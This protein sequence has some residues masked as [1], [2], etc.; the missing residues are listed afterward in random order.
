MQKP[1]ILILKS[2]ILHKKS[3]FE[4]V[5]Q[6]EKEIRRLSIGGSLKIEITLV[7][8]LSRYQIGT[9]EI[10]ERITGNNE[11]ILKELEKNSPLRALILLNQ[12][13]VLIKL[14]K[15]SEAAQ[16]FQEASQSSL[17]GHFRKDFLRWML[18]PSEIDPDLSGVEILKHA[19]NQKQKE[20]N[21]LKSAQPLLGQEA[22]N[23]GNYP[24][25]AQHFENSLAVSPSYEVYFQLC[26]AY[27]KLKRF[28]SIYDTQRFG[29][30]SKTDV[31]NKAKLSFFYGQRDIAKGDIQNAI[32]C[33]QYAL[34]TTDSLRKF[35]VS[36]GLLQAYQRK[37]AFDIALRYNQEALL[38]CNNDPLL[39]ARVFYS[40]SILSMERLNISDAENNARKALDLRKDSEFEAETLI[41]L[42][43][44]EDKKHN[45]SKAVEIV[46]EALKLEIKDPD[47]FIAAHL[48]QAFLY[49]LTTSDKTV[50]YAEALESYEKALSRAT[51]DVLLWAYISFHRAQCHL[52]ALNDP[53]LANLEQTKSLAQADIKA[54]SQCEEH[55]VES[56]LS[57]LIY[58]LYCRDG[59]RGTPKEQLNVLKKK[60]EFS[61]THLNTIP[62]KAH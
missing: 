59:L 10:L 26:R 15:F 29:L 47:T 38:L 5:L 57:D 19:I 2:H 14:N 61:Q 8:A 58:L 49:K 45:T 27:L 21:T 51:N 46:S 56:S 7:S 23:K 44:I 22:Y 48:Q 18:Q 33:Y 36:V 6:T 25:A 28:S 4:Q 41:L 54:V 9:P 3:K 39:Q 16:A 24:A 30:D 35:E 17:Q 20:F 37:G 60:I 62:A 55:F 52:T 32:C 43:M 1:Q 11:D 12:A 42:S 31:N 13:Q 34:K 53:R 40:Q 50:T